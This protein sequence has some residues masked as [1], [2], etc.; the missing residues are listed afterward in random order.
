MSVHVY[1]SGWKSIC[2]AE[3][4]LHVQKSGVPNLVK[5]TDLIWNGSAWQTVCP[6]PSYPFG[7]DYVNRQLQ[8][9]YDGMIPSGMRHIIYH[10]N[11]SD[12][13]PFG[14]DYDFVMTCNIDAHVEPG[15][16]VW[17]RAYSPADGYV[18]PVWNFGPLAPGTYAGIRTFSYSAANYH[19]KLVGEATFD[20]DFQI[21]TEVLV[22]D[23]PNINYLDWSG[24][25]FPFDYDSND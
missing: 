1:Q 12:D 6:V 9:M 14:V 19:M 15:G 17:I 13:Y 22:V 10:E 8:T 11:S 18:T 16:E 2:A 4:T 21:T 3:A 24:I 7:F 5:S 20:S 23:E 25:P